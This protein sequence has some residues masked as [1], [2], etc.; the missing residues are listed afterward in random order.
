MQWGLLYLL[1]LLLLS[2]VALLH[3]PVAKEVSEVAEDGEDAVAH[4]GEHGHQKG[5]LL[6]RFRE[7]LLVQAGVACDILVLGGNKDNK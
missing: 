2:H 7:R 4:V 3:A 1:L 6:K 5:R